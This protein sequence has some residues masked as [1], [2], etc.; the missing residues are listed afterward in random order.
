MDKYYGNGSLFNILSTDCSDADFIRTDYTQSYNPA[1]G[2]IDTYSWRYPTYTYEMLSGSKPAVMLQTLKG[3]LGEENFNKAIN[4]YYQLWKFKHPCGADFVTIMKAAA[5]K[6]AAGDLE[7]AAQ[8]LSPD[9]LHELPGQAHAQGGREILD[10]AAIQL[11]AVGLAHS[12]HHL[13]LQRQDGHGGQG[14]G[15]DLQRAV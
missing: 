3:I 7:Q 4:D 6:V 8:E 9:L 14:L 1:I 5:E 13:E 12:V 10:V 11:K 15:Q 2:V